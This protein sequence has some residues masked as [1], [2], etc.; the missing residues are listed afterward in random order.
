VIN[1]VETF[2]PPMRTLTH[3]VSAGV[4]DR[5]PDVH[6]LFIEGGASWLP[7]AMERMDEAYL[8]HQRFVRP[9]L[10]M[11]PS[12]F[13][14]RQVHASFQH[15]KAALRTLDITGVQAIIWGSDYPHLE[16]TWP[17]SQETLREIL[18]GIDKADADAI[19]GGTLSQLFDLPAPVTSVVG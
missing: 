2:I 17:G 10:S 11:L 8:Q 19:A 12:D 15:D 5:H 18:V 7:S 13:V 14:R 6:V 4:L 1:Y 16:G 9:K 3:L